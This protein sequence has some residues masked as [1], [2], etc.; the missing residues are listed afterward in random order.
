MT[1][2]VEVDYIS[3]RHLAGGGDPAWITVPLHRAC[4][5]RYDHEPLMPRVVLTSLNKRAVLRLEPTVEGQWWALHHTSGE[6][7]P[8]WYASFGA[9]TPV[10]LIAG[11]MDALTDPT[12]S[13]KGPSDPFEPLRRQSWGTAPGAPGLVSADGTAFVQR[14]GNEDDPG[15]WF[16]TTTLQTNRPV[17][18]ARFGEHTPHRLIS[19]FTTALADPQ[20]VWRTNSPLGLPTLDPKVI[21]RHTVTA[22]KALV[23]AALVDRVT[24][25]AARPPAPT[26]EP[27]PPGPPAPRA[28]RR[29]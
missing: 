4:G 16:A 20:S 3:P 26:V 2:T 19:A 6:G 8:D 11:F 18:Q 27:N 12:P 17:W 22:P 10:E 23:P 25:L 15:A 21:S 13:E 29:H 7:Q 14:L 5:W 24:T 28:S 9:R 1:E